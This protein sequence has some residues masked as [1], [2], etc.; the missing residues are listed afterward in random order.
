MPSPVA[1]TRAS[2]RA[3]PQLIT[4]AR[5][6]G[7]TTGRPRDGSVQ[8]SM[9]SSWATNRQGWVLCTDGARVAAVTTERTAVVVS[10]RQPL[11]CLLANTAAW[12]RRSSPSFASRL[13]T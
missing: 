11:G 13:D 9:T 6:S 3:A 7:S 1:A 8:S 4:R 5:P 2:T 12:V 10:H